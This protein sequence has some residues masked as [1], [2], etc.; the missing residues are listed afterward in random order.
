M[1]RGGVRT[2]AESHPSFKRTLQEKLGS[3]GNRR[4]RWS[5][6]SRWKVF[7]V[8]PGE[9]SRRL[10]RPRPQLEAT[11]P[12]CFRM[13]SCKKGA[14]DHDAPTETHE[15]EGGAASSGQ[16][17]KREQSAA[18]PGTHQRCPFASSQLS[19]GIG[20]DP[21]T[22]KHVSQTR[23]ESTLP[24]A[25]ASQRPLIRGV[26]MINR[27]PPGSRSLRLWLDCEMVS[28]AEEQAWGSTACW[29]DEVVLRDLCGGL[30]VPRNLER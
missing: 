4:E 14:A 29:D 30:L 6:A 28:N 18:S 13:H 11:P 7:L 2:S 27:T 26:T 15:S 16:A 21:G 24:P 3:P 22:R 9:V 5:E 17:T 23:S 10:T 12:V 1:S 20:N 25:A 19:L 8:L